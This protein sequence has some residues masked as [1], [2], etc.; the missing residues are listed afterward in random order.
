ML[1]NV[2]QSTKLGVHSEKLHGDKSYG[3]KSS[4]T[5]GFLRTYI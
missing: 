3:D 5:G 2:V 1:K 4:W